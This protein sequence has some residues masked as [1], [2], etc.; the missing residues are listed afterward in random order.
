M[1]GRSGMTNL[2]PTY[3][4]GLPSDGIGLPLYDCFIFSSSVGCNCGGEWERITYPAFMRHNE[5]VV[6]SKLSCPPLRRVDSK[7]GAKTARTNTGRFRARMPLGG[8]V[9]PI[10]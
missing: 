4:I 1:M 2:P 5:W 9:G 10:Q 6:E 7:E 8:G 3:S